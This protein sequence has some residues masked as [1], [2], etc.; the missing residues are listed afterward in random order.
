[1]PAEMTPG[2]ASSSRTSDS[3]KRTRWAGVGAAL[4]ERVRSKSRTL[5]RWR[6]ASAER[7]AMKLW[8]SRPAV[9]SSTT[10]RAVSATMKRRW[11]RWREP[12]TAPRALSL[13]S[14]LMSGR[15]TRRAGARPKSRPVSSERPRV[16][17][18]RCGL[19]AMGCGG[20][21]LAATRAESGS[22]A[23]Q[24]SSRPA[25]PPSRASTTL[26]A[27]S[28]RTIRAALAPRAMRTAISVWRVAA[29]ASRRL[30]TLA[31]AIRSTSAT[32]AMSMTR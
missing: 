12:P 6:P 19:M 21:P 23:N 16:N 25:K 14:L 30:A 26:S 17:R 5:S 29:R 9:K 13:R 7:V 1:M 22:R 8:R 20:A 15:A 32:V 4:L 2:R 31:H 3:T 10:V 28:R 18:S 24:A 11:R 27:R